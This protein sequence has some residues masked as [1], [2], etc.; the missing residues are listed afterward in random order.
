LRLIP[1]V[2]DGSRVWIRY[3]GNL[4]DTAGNPAHAA[5]SI[6]GRFIV[7]DPSLKKRP[8]EH[9]RILLHEYFHFAW[10]RLGNPRRREWEAFLAREWNSGGRGEAGWS[11]E[12]RKQKLTVEDV[13]RRSR[14]WREYCC[15]SFCDTG[16]WIKGGIDTEVTLA[17]SRR[18][19]RIAWFR[20]N[21]RDHLFPI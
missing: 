11:A 19:A 21:F 10:V 1:T 6:I 8:R 3:R 12:W 18:R 5:T 17:V 2:F 14:R 7:L 9:H 4:R 16:A 13:S 15:E 20:R